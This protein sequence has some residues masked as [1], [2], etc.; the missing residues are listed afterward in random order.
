MRVS[1]T[2]FSV[3]V[4]VA[5]QWF[6]AI[7]VILLSRKCQ[8]T[9]KDFNATLPVMSVIALQVAQAMVLVPI[10]AVTT[11]V[12]VAAEMLLTSAASRIVIQIGV[13]LF[14]SA[15]TCFCVIALEL[16]LFTLI[17]NLR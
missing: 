16:Q 13:F 15:L 10:A 6:A 2:R 3:V 5:L 1:F 12:V 4:I 17:Q 14:W 8:T 9:F 7:F 11:A